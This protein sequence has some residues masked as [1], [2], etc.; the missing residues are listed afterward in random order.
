M[1]WQISKM[2]DGLDW[3]REW[4]VEG[5]WGGCECNDEVSEDGE[6]GGKA[7]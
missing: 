2:I 5:T 1:S 6:D 3:G 7:G 4:E